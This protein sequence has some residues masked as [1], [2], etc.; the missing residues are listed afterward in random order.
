[1]IG[2]IGLGN[3]ATAIISGLLE[4]EL[5]KKDEIIG[6][7]KTNESAEKIN[8]AFGIMASTDNKAVAQRSDVIVLAV[9]PQFIDEVIS[10]IKGDI[11]E[12][13]LVI[14]V[15]AG[16]TIEYIKDRFGRDIHI[17]RSMPNTPALIGQGITGVCYG[18]NVTEKEKEFARKFFG[19][20]GLYEEVPERL[21]NAVCSVSGG[22]PAFVFM[23]IEALADGGVE[24][25]LPRKTAYKLAAQTVLGSAA[26][27]LETGKHPGELKDM[28]CS[29]GGT[30]IAG[31]RTLEEKGL[32]AALM[33]AVKASYDKSMGL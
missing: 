6:A 31:V 8:K 32:R 23:I 30:T 12:E 7:C 1:M 18:E 27:M 11:K 25:G 26:L 33:D 29:P 13:A 24:A 4:N 28:V 9:K 20:T 5:V 10:E 3:M 16:K 15:V 14:S 17:V 2:F 22:G 19:A 21:I